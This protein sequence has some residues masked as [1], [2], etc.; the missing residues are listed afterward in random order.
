MFGVPEGS[1]E[2]ITATVLM[3]V[4]LTQILFAESILSPFL[5]SVHPTLSVA[6]SSKHSEQFYILSEQELHCSP[7]MNYVF[8]TQKL[9]S[10]SLRV[11]FVG[12]DLHNK[13]VSALYSQLV[14]SAICAL[15]LK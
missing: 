10:L 6:G 2:L 5:Q 14:Q 9:H 15:H 7:R 3:V 12:H 8:S 11:K 1:K 13:S 4:E